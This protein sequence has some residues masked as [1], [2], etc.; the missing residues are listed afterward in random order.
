VAAAAHESQH[1]YV[2][3][4]IAN[5]TNVDYE[6]DEILPPV[7]NLLA[8]S[9][10]RDKIKSRSG[11]FV[12]ELYRFCARMPV[13]FGRSF[14]FRS[15]YFSEVIATERIMGYVFRRGQFE[16]HPWHSTCYYFRKL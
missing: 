1:R 7:T 15:C 10:G 2:T 12:G 14:L 3:V 8:G 5:N 4:I 16:T 11:I 13:G 6:V 9:R